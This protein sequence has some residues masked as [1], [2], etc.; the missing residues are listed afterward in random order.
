MPSTTGCP[1]AFWLANLIVRVCAWAAPSAATAASATMDWRKSRFIGVSPVGCGLSVQPARRHHDDA[2]EEDHQE[3]HRE[4][5]QH[6]GPDAAR[7]VVHAHL[8][9]AGDGAED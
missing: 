1:L 9:D 8:P 6:E 7:H 4:L 2:G 3:H 5:G